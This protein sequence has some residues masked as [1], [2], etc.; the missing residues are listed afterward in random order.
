MYIRNAEKNEYSISKLKNVKGKFI[1]YVEKEVNELTKGWNLME[2]EKE[3]MKISMK[4]NHCNDLKLEMEDEIGKL[5][6]KKKE[7][8]KDI[9]QLTLKG[10][11]LKSSICEESTIHENE[12]SELLNNRRP[13]NDLRHGKKSM[14][15]KDSYNEKGCK[16]NIN[17]IRNG[18]NS[19]PYSSK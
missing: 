7:L 11:A 13:Y 17:E 9:E 19:G 8:V 10:K 6:K 4:K 16:E 12:F 18:T 5:A 2:E 14:I 3:R 1:E 15:I